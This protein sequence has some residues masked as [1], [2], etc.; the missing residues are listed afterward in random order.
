MNMTPEEQQA[1][2]QFFGTV[3]AQARQT[4][5]M[6]VGNSQFVKPVSPVIQH[7][8]EEALRIPVQHNSP[9]QSYTQPVPQPAI[10]PPVVI[11]PPQE[12]LV[13]YLPPASS[14]EVLGNNETIEVL[15]EISLNLAR[16]ANILEKKNG[17][18][19]RTKPSNPA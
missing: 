17:T 13:N 19:K 6:I 15:K 16:I 11:Q 7:Q 1:L 14:L 8:L 4:D 10:E 5:Q 2:V 18:P 12:A 9:N 3:H